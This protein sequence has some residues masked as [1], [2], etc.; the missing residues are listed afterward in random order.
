MLTNQIPI[1]ESIL[2]C[3]EDKFYDMCPFI[4]KDFESC[5]Y[6]TLF[7]EDERSLSIFNLGKHGFKLPPTSFYVRPLTIGA[8]MLTGHR[9]KKFTR[10]CYGP[11]PAIQVVLDY[12]EKVSY[13]ASRKETKHNYFQFFWSTSTTHDYIRGPE[14]I[15]GPLEEALKWWH[16]GKYLRNTILIVMSDHGARFGKIHEYYQGLIEDRLPALYIYVPERFKLAH[17]EEYRNLVNNQNRL[18]HAVDL[19]KTLHHILT[20]RKKNQEHLLPEKN[21]SE[22]YSTGISLFN[23]IPLNRTCREA[24]IAE[25]YCT[26]NHKMVP[27]SESDG[28]VMQA[29]NFVVYEINRKF[30]DLTK[31]AF[32]KLERVIRAGIVT[33]GDDVKGVDI[34]V[35]YQIAFE[36]SPGNGRFEALLLHG[37]DKKWRLS[38]EVGRSNLYG[39]DSHCVDDKRLKLYCFCLNITVTDNCCEKVSTP[40]AEEVEI[41]EKKTIDVEGDEEEEEEEDEE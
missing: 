24:G 35:G 1:N 40:F 10:F 16:Q 17:S 19:H 13:L 30:K 7:G 28:M 5:G 33:F 32:L 18:M 3:E 25:A 37:K 2:P 29:A 41:R 4:W 23:P 11:R 12:M 21:T 34:W 9:K 8:D 27:V 26:C 39:N 22:Y 14:N 31:C 15:D 38:G 36:T 6:K 20:F